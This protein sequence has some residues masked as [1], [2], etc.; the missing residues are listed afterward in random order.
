MHGILKRICLRTGAKRQKFS[1]LVIIV[2]LRLR[3]DYNSKARVIKQ[4]LSF[5]AR[6]SYYS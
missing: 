4:L 1:S 5:I 3:I 2:G 6:I